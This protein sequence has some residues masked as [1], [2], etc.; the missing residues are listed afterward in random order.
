MALLPLLGGLGLGLAWGWL[1]GLRACP[2]HRPLL[3][4]FALAGATL[5]VGLE[6]WLFA[7]TWA[8]AAFACGA[9]LALP[10]YL[11]WLRSLRRR[12]GAGTG[13]R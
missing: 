4:A 11:G 10:A 7:G 1:V 12:F 13:E 5:L 6:V 3:Q 8:T 2:A 9:A